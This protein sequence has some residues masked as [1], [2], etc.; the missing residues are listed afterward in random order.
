MVLAGRVIIAE[1]GTILNVA[2]RWNH[3]AIS[4][5]IAAAL[6]YKSAYHHLQNSVQP[7]SL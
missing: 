5:V 3:P 1:P 6:R 4:E 2:L 7:S